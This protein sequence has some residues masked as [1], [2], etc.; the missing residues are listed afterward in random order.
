MEVATKG[1]PITKQ[2]VWESYKK[3]KSKKIIIESLKI[4]DDIVE[5]SLLDEKNILNSDNYDIY[6]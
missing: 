2:M 4:D 1:I 6:K 5:S 3:V